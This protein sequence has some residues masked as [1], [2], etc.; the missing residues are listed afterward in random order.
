M[1]K[2]QQ[3]WNWIRV[4][5]HD[6]GTI[7]LARI[8][9]LVG[10][11]WAVLVMS[12]LTGVLPAKWLP[13]WLIISGV[14]TEMVRRSNEPHNLGVSTTADLNAVSVSVKTAD[15]M[16]VNKKDGTIKITKAVMPEGL[17]TKK[18]GDRL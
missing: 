3:L 2:L 8:Q 18:S 14:I 13:Y 7:L 9:L 5:S 6:S 11:I 17:T 1:S 12:D 10:S 16:V 4:W 15:T